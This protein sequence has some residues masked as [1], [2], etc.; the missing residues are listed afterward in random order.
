MTLTAIQPLNIQTISSCRL[1][2]NIHQAL[3]V[4]PAEHY[5]VDAE[6]LP[7]EHFRVAR[8]VLQHLLGGNTSFSN[9][10]PAHPKS[11]QGQ[12]LFLVYQSEKA[13]KLYADAMETPLSEVTPW[14]V[15]QFFARIA[16]LDESTVTTD[17]ARAQLEDYLYGLRSYKSADVVLSLKD[18]PE[19]GRLLTSVPEDLR[20]W[21]V[22]FKRGARLMSVGEWI[23]RSSGRSLYNGIS[24]SRGE[25]ARRAL[26][27]CCD[28][29][30]AL[31][32]PGEYRDRALW[33]AIEEK[34]ATIEVW[35]LLEFY[36]KAGSQI[37]SPCEGL[38]LDF[39][40]P[41]PSASRAEFY[42][43]VVA[44]AANPDDEAWLSLAIANAKGAPGMRAL[45]LGTELH[46]KYSGLAFESAIALA[47]LLLQSQLQSS[48]VLDDSLPT[49][50]GLNEHVSPLDTWS[51]VHNVDDLFQQLGIGLLCRLDGDA[52]VLR[53]RPSQT[54]HALI[55]T[56]RFK[57]IF[58]PLLNSMQWYGALTHEQ[59]SPLVTQALAGRAVVDYFLGA[60][61]TFTEPLAKTLRGAWVCEYSH[62]QLCAKVRADIKARQ[63]GVSPPVLEMLFYLLVRE[64]MPELL[65]EGVPDHLQYGRS[66]QSVALIHGVALLESMRPG[67]SLAPQYDALVGISAELTQSSDANVHA[68]WARTLAIP[69]L[70]YAIAHGGIE[71]SG[72][73][74]LDQASAAQ[75]SQALSYFKA[76]QELH[77]SE[78][79]DLLSARPPDRKR[80][81]EQMLTE[82]NVDRRIWPLSIKVHGWPIL[83]EHGFTIANSYSIDRLL[84][85]GRPQASVLELVMMGEAYIKGKPTIPEAYASAFDSFQRELTR[86]EARVMARLLAEMQVTDRT[87]LLNSTCEVSRVAFGAEEGVHGLF[88]R[89]QPGDHR[90]DFHDHK[91]EEVFYELI[92]AG[93]VVRKVAQRFQYKIEPDRGFSGNIVET[94]EKRER[95]AAKAAKALVTPLLPLDGDAYLKGTASRSSA[96]YHHPR[97]GV[98]VPCAELI[99][100][101]GGSEQARLEAFVLVAAS[102]LFTRFLEGSRVE[103]EHVTQWEQLWAKE[104]EYADITA[105]LLIPFYGC[106]TD[107]AHGE[108]S[109]GVIVGCVMEVAFALIPAGQFAGSTARIVMKAG[110]MSVLSVFKLTG[111]A[112]ARL[113]AGLAEQSALFVVRDV[114]KF[115]LKVGRLGWSR[116]LEQV[117]SLKK[118]FASQA[119]L[120]SGITLD[121]GMYRIADSA[122]H[123]WRPK[124]KAQDKRAV[125][126]GRSDVVVRNVGTLQEPDFRLLDPESDAVFGKR[127]TSVSKNR[128]LE[129]SIS[130]A[131]EGIGPGHY[132]VVLPVTSQVGGFSELRIAPNYA[133]QVIERE[134]GVFDILVD[135]EVYHLNAGATDA[136]MRKLAASKLSSHA[137]WLSEIENLCRP[138]RNLESVPCATGVKLVTPTP[139]PLRPGSTSPKRTGKYP[140][141]AMDA[142]EFTLATLTTGAGE[143]SQSLD[144]FVYEG[145]FCKWAESSEAG[146]STSAQAPAPAGKVVVPLSEE[147]R[148]LF[149]LPEAPVYL[150][151]LDGILSAEGKLGVP[152]NYA[153]EDTAFVYEFAPVIEFGAIA[154]GVSDTRAL[155]G[156]RLN[157]AD[158][159][160]IFVEPDTGAFYK[161]RAP[162][163]NRIE[164]KF[165]RVTDVDE[166]NEFIRVSEKYRLV[167]ER[168]NIETDRENIARLLFDLL[169]ESERDAWKVSWTPQIASYDDYARWCIANGQENAL[170][171]FA[172]EILAGEEI[173]KKFVELAKQCIPDF[174]KIAQRSVPEKQHILEVL[175][176]LL[177]VA[178]S[179]GKW[180]EL[181]MQSI[182]TPKAT[183][184]ILSQI[185]GANLSFAQVYTESGERVVYY[186]LS[187]GE[188]AR[189]LKLRIDSAETTEQI[190]DGVIFRD[191]RARMASRQPDPRFTSLPVVR[192]AARTVIR[193]FSRDLDAERLI[194]T[195]LKE[196]MATTRLTHIRF[197]T[198]LDTCRSCGG[199]V[200]P[201]LK[202]DF[203][204]ALFSVT[205][206]KNYTFS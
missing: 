104:R 83:Q 38:Q 51:T 113:V 22:Q 118:V 197:F 82:A 133:V 97:Q 196:D 30:A 32:P 158:K 198:V 170:L 41:T 74:N 43:K 77:A 13:W 27:V 49:C 64:A 162:T 167:R 57:S 47:A 142:R 69:A 18:Y 200:L 153:P 75:I 94:V 189:G 89:C 114:G 143:T 190:F 192:D 148:E 149:S 166:I 70:R 175:N 53:W 172:S 48:R 194:A 10:S 8:L 108:H 100:L 105:R 88:V 44:Y 132:P 29:I 84:A 56:A 14:Q 195:V 176:R 35:W 139:E 127:L 92:P 181:N 165:A 78:L 36:L 60:T 99:H 101:P 156:M 71:W 124:V 40:T 66:L 79:N 19:L 15:H 187:G 129:F 87:A 168:P 20:L 121:K 155:R 23:A 9:S 179:K 177:P 182:I 161:T 169:D 6:A 171:G 55:Q 123:P 86:A 63:P 164:L 130:S 141:H 80:L 144:V 37:A 185:K 116:L 152:P 178:G 52:R 204:D 50:R 193:D 96:V 201:R 1:F 202:L 98:L 136:A 54:W 183:K 154:Q 134:E 122:E 186:A 119:F 59:A 39:L 199:F 140:S 128:P 191:A 138:R 107:L 117:P 5:M 16:W 31:I 157:L 160:W 125:V 62:V 33:A 184:A 28:V 24:A 137:D 25:K 90:A 73:D 180:V 159:E 110:E 203:P 45:S 163:S 103:H 135:G 145:K 95:N 151:E 150:P 17:T 115:A 65:V 111:K 206:L 85:A 146:P 7:D 106:A 4:D 67:H 58:A 72:A 3:G 42:R 188:K 102:H 68:L 91:A 205:Y 12:K 61:R 2:F 126:D 147:E 46:C 34:L 174:M 112:V 11:P 93:G 21:M 109:A 76:Q 131:D 173:Q 120:E 26:S 81:A